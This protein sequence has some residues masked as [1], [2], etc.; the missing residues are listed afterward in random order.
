MG[1]LFIFM[2]VSLDGFFEGPSHDLSWHNIDE[3]FNA[4]S[5][6]QLNEIGVI[7]FGRRTYELMASYWPSHEAEAEGDT[8][9]TKKMNSLPKVVF[10]STLKRA[11]WGGSD[12][13]IK[14]IKNNIAPEVA[15]LKQKYSQDLAIFGSS[16]LGLSLLKLELIDELRIMI[17][18]VVLGKGNAVFS[19]LRDK[20]KLR[21]VTARTFRSGNVL[22]YFQPIKSNSQPSS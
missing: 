11:P 17:N 3:E 21:L 7:L 22:L 8:D 4:F 1:K 13:N 5:S 15:R 6:K 14:L 10:S 19:G 2:M 9:I 16:E 20:L 12:D 18:P